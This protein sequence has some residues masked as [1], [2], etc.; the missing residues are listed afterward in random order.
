MSQPVWQCSAAVAYL[1]DDFDE[2]LRQ[3]YADLRTKPTS[4]GRVRM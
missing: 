2:E 3:S 4:L 1:L